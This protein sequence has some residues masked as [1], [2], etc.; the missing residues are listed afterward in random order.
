M[1]NNSLRF[2]VEIVI[3][4]KIFYNFGKTFGF[5]INLDQ[6]LQTRAAPAEASFY[7]LCYPCMGGGIFWHAKVVTNKDRHIAQTIHWP[8]VMGARSPSLRAAQKAKCADVNRAQAPRALNSFKVE[9][10][11]SHQM[12][13]RLFMNGA[14]AWDQRLREW[15]IVIYWALIDSAAKAA[16]ISSAAARN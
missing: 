7:I 3:K 15:L 9:L 1:Q 12:Q 8:G 11:S 14:I 2:Y 6:L 16:R 5:W 13:Q 4:C 10:I